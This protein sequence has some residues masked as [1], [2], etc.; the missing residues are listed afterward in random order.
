LL[1]I[2]WQAPRAYVGGL[3]V[4]MAQLAKDALQDA[5]DAYKASLA[6]AEAYTAGYK[7]GY[8]AGQID[9]LKRL[10]RQ[11]AKRADASIVYTIEENR[12]E[13]G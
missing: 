4:D 10:A 1:A 12:T 5:A 8:N 7:T 11:D 2:G 13:E 9:E 3:T 6:T